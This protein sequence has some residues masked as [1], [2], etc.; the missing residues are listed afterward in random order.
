MAALEEAAT[1]IQIGGGWWLSAAARGM[2]CKCLRSGNASLKD[3]LVG[4]T[5]AAEGGGRG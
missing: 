5:V 3:D 2:G 1:T 4:A